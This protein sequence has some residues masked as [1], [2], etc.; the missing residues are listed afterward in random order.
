[1]AMRFSETD[2]ARVTASVA[3]AEEATDGEIVTIVAGRS[4]D[5]DDVAFAWAVAAM[6]AVTGI[7]LAIPG[8]LEGINALLTNG[9]TDH[10]DLRP[11]I[12]ALLA[13][14]TAV[15][16]G[17]RQ[18]LVLPGLRMALTPGGVRTRNVRK[19]AMQYFRTSAEKR[20]IGRVGILL[21]L[22]LDEHRA[23]LIGD[24]AITSK[25][26]AERWGDAM[27]ALVEQVKAGDPAGG[28]VAA[29]EAIGA[30][31]AEHF[32]K[33]SADTNELP[34]RLIEL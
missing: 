6:L 26:E 3:K 34:D 15:F 8:A 7:V 1:M 16:L 32:P 12:V 19:R 20:T 28:M 27:A 31:L 21:Y 13:V 10:A 18:L 30:I 11:L 14:Q 5:Y 4:D 17:V 24:E 23:E 22:S 2:H 33:T 25:V 29:V 9:W